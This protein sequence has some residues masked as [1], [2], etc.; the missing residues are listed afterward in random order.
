MK[1]A[2]L[3]SDTIAAVAT[4]SGRG[5]VGLVRLS[6]P[7]ALR[8]GAS[9]IEVQKFASLSDCPPRRACLG[10]VHAD[11]LAVD[12]VMVTVF[13]APQ[14]YT[15]E[16]IVEISCHGGAV[17]LKRVLDLCFRSG[18]RA[19]EPGE[20]S[21]RAFLNGKMDL[22]QAEAVADLIDARTEGSRAAALAQVEGKLSRPVREVRETLV[23]ML[24]HL[25]VN[26]DHS[27]DATVGA[28]MPPAEMDRRLRGAIAIL[29]GLARSYDYGRLLKEGLRVAIVGRPNVGK[30]SLLNCLLGADRAI[31][32]D[33]PGTTRDTLEEG[34]DL[35][36]IPAVLI[37]TAGIREHADPVEKIGIERTHRAIEQA[38]AVILLLD[39]SA[40]WNAA[41][42]QLAALLNRKE[43]IVAALNKSDLP[44][45]MNVDRARE[46]LPQ[47]AVVSI[48]SLS[49][50]GV[51]NLLKELSRL[52]AAPR[53]ESSNGTKLNAVINEGVSDPV[54][55]TSLRH[56]DA[57]AK[58]LESLKR[59]LEVCGASDMEEC[60]ALELR[61]ALD[62]LGAII[63]ETVTEDILKEIF[64]KFCI[65]K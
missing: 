6:G 27:D 62:S 25:E 16:D 12:R 58:A 24:A 36:G 55:V 32:T 64:S 21:Q 48:S 15:G 3:S 2:Y 51:E 52:A 39:Q 35:N 43:K 17:I 18:A 13:R 42:A 11:G 34:F 1:N 60:Q 53:G 5:A 41:D 38:D 63:G 33:I 8:L 4:P 10:E 30:S 29:D 49:G 20:F 26:L 56:R 54:W 22:A 50:A 46:A 59:A 28:T 40:D 7:E 47:A 45:K 31:V 44:T 9:F 19:A 23:E 61:E 37:D 57:L 14:S 65:G